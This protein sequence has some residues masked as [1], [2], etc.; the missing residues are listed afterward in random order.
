M[1][2]GPVAGEMGLRNGRAGKCMC[3]TTSAHVTRHLFVQMS[4]KKKDFRG[5]VPAAVK[6]YLSLLYVIRNGFDVNVCH[7][8]STNIGSSG[9]TP[10]FR[11]VG[12]VITGRIWLQYFVF[13][14]PDTDQRIGDLV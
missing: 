9:F 1:L 7:S 4:K 3:D 12:Y 11:S 14:C 8:H 2:D 10:G 6:A 13:T 5:E